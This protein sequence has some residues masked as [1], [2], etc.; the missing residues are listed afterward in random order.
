MSKTI[1]HPLG[2][3]IKKIDQTDKVPLDCPVCNFSIRDQSDIMSYIDYSCCSEC[4]ASW[5]EPN[6]SQWK[7][8]WRPSEDKIAKYRENLLSRPSYLV[9]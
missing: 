6:S 7:D 2:F 5:A 9:N 4:Q 8:G 1:K 3:Y